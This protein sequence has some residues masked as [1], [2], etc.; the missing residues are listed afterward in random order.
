M[1]ES[2]NFS[3]EAGSAKVIGTVSS[4]DIAEPVTPPLG[5]RAMGPRITFHFVG[6]WDAETSYVLYDV[7]CVN[8]T[9]YIG[10][11]I[12]IA[13]GV[14]PETDNNVHWVKWNDPNAQ[15]ELL[16]QTVNAFD[17]RITE[18]EAEATAATADAAE[19]KKASENNSK[20]ISAETT[21][22]TAAEAANT[23][24]I[25]AEVT[26]ARTAEAAN[27]AAIR[28]NKT[29]V[30]LKE[31][32]GEQITNAE[33]F[34]NAIKNGGRFYVP[35]GT[36]EMDGTIAIPSNIELF[37]D[38]AATVFKTSNTVGDAYHSMCS[39]NAVDFGAREG[40]NSATGNYPAWTKYCDHLVSNVYLHDFKID[41][42]QAVRYTGTQ[43]TWR[44]PDTGGTLQLEFGTGIEMQYCN[45]V[46][47]ERVTVVN[48]IQHCINVRGG[49]N[50][51]NMGDT[52][53]TEGKSENV[54]I[55]NCVAINQRVDD[56]I[57]VHDSH[58]IL[59][60]GC[61]AAVP[62]NVTVYAAAI[63]NG[64]EI[65]DGSYDVVVENCTSEYSFVGY[66]AKGHENTAPA[67]DVTFQN[68]VA[69]YTQIG[70]DI[71]H[72]SVV[73]TDEYPLNG[74]LYNVK[75]INCRIIDNY[76]FK[77]VTDYRGETYLIQLQNAFNCLIDGLVYDRKAT[78]V[79]ANALGTSDRCCVWFRDKNQGHTFQ[80]MSIN[81]TWPSSQST[82]ALSGNSKN[83][84]IIGCSC[85]NPGAISNNTFVYIPTGDSL[86]Q[87]YVIKNNTVVNAPTGLTFCNREN[88]N[89]RII[90]NN[91]II[92]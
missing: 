28:E 60:S 13:K 1:T 29:A 92:N 48:A 15:V 59:I 90:E 57:T 85:V 44:N 91:V 61:Y 10:N 3:A 38:G 80:N 71:T 32:L 87:Y 82:F 56:C 45:N 74:D 4:T 22:A 83:I 53:V 54:K 14:N 55:I 62:N 2:K 36:Y 79:Q 8:G 9:S 88:S 25:E 50:G 77:N 6:E 52:Y 35:A 68:C 63:S 67:H 23:A 27:T 65:D 34:N 42:N 20:A 81:N 51:Y 41:G 18:A 78:S 64:I 24:A 69:R 84:K 40:R 33:A 5:L 58:N 86:P 75:I 26:R 47:I 73:S 30:N 16:Q 72:G 19:A 76:A 21:R 39:D 46:T 17:G 66:Q 12:N 49:S 7:V 89:N 70:F 11:K 31:A 43:P 37:G